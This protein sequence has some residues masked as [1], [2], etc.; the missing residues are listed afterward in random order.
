MPFFDR[1]GARIYYEEK[2]EGFPLLTI[3][4]GGMKSTVAS[5][6]NAAV[7]PWESYAGDFRMV[8]M[9]QRNA[10]QSTG[11]FD[12]EDPWGAYAADQL[13]LLDHLGIDRF[14]VMGCCI[15]G[16]FILELIEVAP[17]RVVAAVLEQPIGVIDAN[18]DLFEQ[19]QKSWAGEVIGRRDGI[20]AQT[21]DRFL[22]EMWAGEFVVSV[23]RTMISK[24]PVPLLVM[25]GIDDYHPTETG[26]EIVALAP[27]AR[28]LE[29]W[30][31]T[32]EH[33]AAATEQ[34]RRFLVEHAA[35]G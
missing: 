26:R 23:D 27:D 11:P 17:E 4:P 7:D 35:A 22:T 6:A 18:R 29:P 10:G 2:G 8:A 32:P 33:I 12:L 31:D 21:V 20:D 5:W 25:P 30:K 14:L 28:V 19:M 15:G 3:A 24:C 34:V 9:D 1:D 16:S 13:G